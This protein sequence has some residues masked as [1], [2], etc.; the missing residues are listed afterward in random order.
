MNVYIFT[1]CVVLN[2]RDA[3]GL[4]K[5]EQHG[6]D[7]IL[8]MHQ[9]NLIALDVRTS[10]VPSRVGGPS[11]WNECGQPRPHHL[12]SERSDPHAH[13]KTTLGSGGVMGFITQQL[14]SLVDIPCFC[15]LG[16]RLPSRG[17]RADIGSSPH[18]A[19]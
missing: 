7:L 3:A 11:T 6:L 14:L 18:R 4:Q 13:L 19:A 2:L 1:E 10:S 9:A 12:G 17:T 15:C 16:N 5:L 8:G